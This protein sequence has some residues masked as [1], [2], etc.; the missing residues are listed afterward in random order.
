MNPTKLIGILLIA[1]GGLGLAYGGFSYPQESTALK[2][3]TLELKVKETKTVDI[4]TI[5]S[6]GAIVM[7]GI[8]LVFSRK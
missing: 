4:P 8:L 5:L 7:G 1:A 3:G 6:I 2:L